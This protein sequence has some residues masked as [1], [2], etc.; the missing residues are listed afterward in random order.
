MDA[1]ERAVLEAC[2]EVVQRQH[3]LLPLLAAAI[4]VREA[5]VFYTWALRKCPQHG[6]VPETNW[7]FFFHGLECDL[8]N[9]TD[10]RFLRIDFGD[11][12]ESHGAEAGLSHRQF[13]SRIRTI[14]Q[15]VLRSDEPDRK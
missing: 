7:R 5:D 4:Q 3:E 15:A 11:F 14:S 8:H 2:Q 13:H 9:K 1:R 10:G 6:D 12:L